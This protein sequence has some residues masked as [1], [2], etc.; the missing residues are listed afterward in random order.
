MSSWKKDETVGNQFYH[1][2]GASFGTDVSRVDDAIA[3]HVVTVYTTA[4]RPV[5]VS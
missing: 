4:D 3:R 1:L 5:G 2:K